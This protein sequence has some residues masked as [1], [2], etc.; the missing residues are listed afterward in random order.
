MHGEHLATRGVRAKMMIS[1]ATKGS[2]C[3]QVY[4]YQK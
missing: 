4:N 1:A 2:V 3:H